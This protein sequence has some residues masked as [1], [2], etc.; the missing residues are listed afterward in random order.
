MLNRE[1]YLTE[2]TVSNIFFVR[3]G[4]LFTPSHKTG[5][6]KGITRQVVL[7]LAQS[8]GMKIGENLFFP[9]DLEKAD[10]CFLTNTSME[11][12]PV[13]RVGKRR[14]GRGKPGPVTL[15]LRKAFKA[16]VQ[17]ECRISE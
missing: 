11:V 5:L 8:A 4:C 2:G 12:M 15:K 1:G 10:E 9:A 13:T 7:E 6:L 3:K 14:I 17:E 16:L